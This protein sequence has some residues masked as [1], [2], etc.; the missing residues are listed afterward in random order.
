VKN[1]FPAPTLSVACLF[2]G[3]AFA[4]S[5]GLRQTPADSSNQPIFLRFQDVQWKKAA[6][7]RG[8]CTFEVAVIRVDPQTHATQMLIRRP[9]NCHVPRHSHTA[10]EAITVISGTFILECNGKREALTAGSFAYVPSQTVH[11]AWTKPDEGSLSF[12]SMDGPMD[13]HWVDASVAPPQKP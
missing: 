1:V 3:L 12:V 7:P 6:T 13:A 10:S 5:A 11:E 4:H 2:F 8:D 9:A